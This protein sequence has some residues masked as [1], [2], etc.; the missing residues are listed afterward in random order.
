MN[1]TFKTCLMGAFIMFSM[2][3]YA[4][5][6]VKLAKAEG[7]HTFEGEGTENLIDG[8]LYTK[9]CFLGNGQKGFPYEVTLTAN[10]AFSL[11]KYVMATADDTS[12]YPGRN[13][14]NWKVMGSNDKKKWT[15]LDE[16]KYNWTMDAQNEQL[17]G[18]DV[19][20]AP[21]FKYYLFV[22]NRLQEGTTIQLSEIMLYK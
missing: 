4:Q 11:K 18:F 13:P 22:F 2:G 5:T 15:L 8:L 10:E 16:K 14:M 19:Q 17:F 7:P 6:K 1:R 21:S 12:S 9:W 3:L 20:N